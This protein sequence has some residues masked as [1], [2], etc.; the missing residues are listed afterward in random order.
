MNNTL[1]VILASLSMAISSG[2]MMHSL[3]QNQTRQEIHLDP[4]LERLALG[5]LQEE[6]KRREYVRKV[7]AANHAAERDHGFPLEV[8]PVNLNFSNTPKQ[9]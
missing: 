7:D 6:E 8:P 3:A 4:E 5:F 9:K 1:A 2:T